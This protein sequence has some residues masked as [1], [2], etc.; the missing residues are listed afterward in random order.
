[1]KS[2]AM[3]TIVFAV[4]AVGGFALDEARHA[5]DR[6]TPASPV[7][8]H[9]TVQGHGTKNLVFHCGDYRFRAHVEH[10]I[11]EHLGSADVHVWPGCTIGLT[12]EQ[13]QRKTL[14]AIGIY[15]RLHGVGTI[16]LIA[17]RDCGGHGGSRRHTG[18]V[19]EVAYHH[20]DLLKSRRVILGQFPDMEVK[21]YFV[22][23]DRNG[24][25]RWESLLAEEN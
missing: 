25:F 6:P 23:F 1:M 14:D 22:E 9:K 8:P 7:S 24:T 19:E 21:I 5:S 16:H 13:I 20:Q 12:D 15:R 18:P 11:D 3:L 2:F 10:W 4:G 17:H